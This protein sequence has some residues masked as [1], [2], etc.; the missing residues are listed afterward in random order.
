MLLRPLPHAF[1]Q[2]VYFIGTSIHSALINF[3]NLTVFMLIYR[4]P[5]MIKRSANDTRHDKVSAIL[6]TSYFYSL[7]IS[8]LLSLFII[9]D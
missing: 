3:L 2:K 4:N 7:E 5:F 1:S 8:S 9:K 6:I